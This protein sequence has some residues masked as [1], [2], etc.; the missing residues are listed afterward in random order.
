[1]GKTVIIAEKPSVGRDI[2]RVLK[3]GVRGEGFLAS[4]NTIITWAVGHLVSLEEPDGLDERYKKW[5]MQDL[6]ILPDSI[7]LKVLPKTKTQFRVIQKLMNDKDTEKLICATDAG[8][9][10]ELIFRYIYDKAGCQKPVERLWI[11]SMTDEAIREGFNTLR[12]SQDY[13][14]LYQSAKCRSES[15]WLV[16]MNLSRAFTLRYDTLLSIGRVQTPT[17][18][19]LVKRHK[20]I[21]AFQKEEYY[22]LSAD[23]GDYQGLWFKEG[24]PNDTRIE[25]K[26]EADRLAKLVAQKP[27][28][29][30]SCESARKQDA[31]PQLYDLTTLQRDANR[32]L[33]FTAQKTL[34]LAQSLYETY[35]AITYPRTDSRY[36]SHDMVGRTAQTLKALPQPYQPFVAGALPEGKLPFSRRVFDDEKVTDHHAILPTPK[37]VDLSKLPADEQKVFDLIARRALQAFYPPFVYDA[38][39]IITL[40]ENETFRSTGRTIIDPGFKVLDPVSEKKKKE[41]NDAPLPLLNAGD[42]R[43]VQKATVK[44]DATKPPAPHTDGTLLYA[45]E[46]AGREVEDEA[47]RESMKS[48]GLGTPAT[49]AAIIERLCKVGYAQRK[50]KTIIATE[51]GVQLI[52]IMPKELSSPEMT[53]QWEQGLEEIAAGKRDTAQFIADIK[54]FTCRLV[55]FARENRLETAFP[56]EQRKAS[57]KKISAPP[58]PDV[59][60]PLCGQGTVHENQKAFYCSRFREGC[61]LTLWKNAL[62]RGGGPALSDK[63][64]TLVLKDKNVRGSTG[65]IALDHKL[66]TFTRAGESMPA[67]QAPIEGRK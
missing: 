36:L 32:L 49:R 43:T 38:A 54:A 17:L 31:A 19:L 46:H 50:G 2:A 41:E 35:K 40:C 4:E 6:P 53:G 16:G 62:E 9:E 56:A 66:L 42:T 45:M 10:G 23:F 63:L 48:V 47:L 37:T 27:A 58:L 18:A 13:E 33:G 28:T 67:V 3:C 25:Q 21:A 29:V 7:P 8:R 64:V 24:K 51:K 30:L 11:S 57:G 22:L 55:A 60:C 39:K 20:E 5:R 34:S 65:V 15:D 52:Q 26:E 14:G 61:R 44:K 1:M 12:P 59:V